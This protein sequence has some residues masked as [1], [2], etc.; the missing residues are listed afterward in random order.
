MEKFRAIDAV[1]VPLPQSNID[2]DQITP[3]RFL[4]RP[5]DDNHGAYLFRDL[6]PDARVLLEAHADDL[7]MAAPSA[8]RPAHGFPLAWCF[9]YGS[10]RVFYT[11]LGHF[12]GAYEDAR[13]LGHLQGGLSWLL[14][15][16]KC[17]EE[18]TWTSA[19]S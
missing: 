8:R 6:R 14:R 3:A 11:A 2:T 12:P 7:D 4:H 17:P 19:I 15:T 16:E 10:G 5:R 18:G 1:A 9:E 13:F